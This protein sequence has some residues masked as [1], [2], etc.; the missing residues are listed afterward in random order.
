MTGQADRQGNAS[1]DFYGPQ[2]ARF[3]GALAVALRREVYGEDLGQQGGR[4]L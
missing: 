1:F 2:Y 3:D 4:V